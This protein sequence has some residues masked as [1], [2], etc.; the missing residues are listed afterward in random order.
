MALL[1]VHLKRSPQLITI[2]SLAHFIAAFA[3][4]PLTA[5]PSAIKLVG[6]AMILISFNYYL[7][8]D[9]LLSARN[10]V[11]V[12]ELS[13]GMQCTLKT[14]SGESIVC[15][16]QSS[17]FVAPYLTVLNLKPENQFFTRSVVILPDSIDADVFRRLRVLLKWKWR[18]IKIQSNNT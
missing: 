10:A 11:V 8:K 14:Q 4:Y 7:K 3:L 1:T 13:D 16:I 12:F 18:D 6:V 5:I 15:T 2:L 17:T 9:A